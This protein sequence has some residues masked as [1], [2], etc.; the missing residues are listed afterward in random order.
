MLIAFSSS[1]TSAAYFAVEIRLS[2]DHHK[3]L[4]TRRRYGTPISPAI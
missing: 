4:A 1:A 3:L 2:A